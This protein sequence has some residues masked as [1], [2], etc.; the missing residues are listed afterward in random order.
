MVGSR[1]TDRLV[2]ISPASAGGTPLATYWEL[3]MADVASLEQ[4][5]ARARRR[6]A[7]VI[8][9]RAD[10]PTIHLHRRRLQLAERQ[11]E[12]AKAAAVLSHFP[13]IGKDPL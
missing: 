7:D 12:A 10:P 6:L 2:M 8:A 5:V 3:G 13:G 4:R 9:D 11:L 1:M